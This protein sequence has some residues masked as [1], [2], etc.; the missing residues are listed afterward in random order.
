MDWTVLVP[1]TTALVVI[2]I[3]FCCF[4]KVIVGFVSVVDVTVVDGWVFCFVVF[5]VFVFF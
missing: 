2:V 3:G 5:K 1:V 4:I